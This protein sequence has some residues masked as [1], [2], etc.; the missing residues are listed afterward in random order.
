MLTMA[1]E[2][3]P[4][5]IRAEFIG[6]YPSRQH[7]DHPEQGCAMAAL[8]PEVARGAP[9]R[10]TSPPALTR[11]SIRCPRARASSQRDRADAISTIAALVGAV[12]LARA[13][14]DPTLSEEIP[15]RSSRPF[16]LTAGR[17]RRALISG[18][19]SS[20][21]H[22]DRP[23]PHSPATLRRARL[24]L[25]QTRSVISRLGLGGK[26]C[27][28]LTLLLG[29]KHADHLPA[30]LRHTHPTHVRNTFQPDQH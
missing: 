1:D 12:V 14:D 24:R 4:R 15:G 21:G 8:A 10:H 28:Q 26:Q 13:V 25:S 6:G 22:H 29:N 11:S 20:I 7:R 23:V 18:P 5:Q 30:Y 17:Q 19:A 27:I 16:W 9:I 2:V 3:A